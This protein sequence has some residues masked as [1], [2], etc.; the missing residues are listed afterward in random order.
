VVVSGGLVLGAGYVLAGLVGTSFVGLLIT[1]GVVAGAGIG[2]AYVVPIAVGVRWFPDMKGLITGLAVAGFGF[3][4]LIWVKLAG[5]WGHLIETAGVSN[6]FMIYGVVF[7]LVVLAGSLVMKLP[8]EGWLPAGYVPPAAGAGDGAPLE[9]G[10]AAMLRTPQFHLLW[11]MFVFGA[12]AGLQVIGTIKLFGIDALEASGLDAATASAT[13]GTAMA[14]FYSLSNGFGRIAWGAISDRIG[15]KPALVIMMTLQGVVMLAFYRMGGS[16][17]LLYLGAALIGFNFG[18]N[19][20]LFPAATADYF[21]SRFLGANYGWVFS[22]Y[23]L[24]GIFGPMLGGIVRDQT[25]NFLFA[26]VPAG[27]ACLLAA[28]LGVLLTPPLTPAD[29]VKSRRPVSAMQPQ[30][31]MVD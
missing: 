16:P 1:I 13:A 9:L 31:A 28:L 30:S 14:V 29:R 27:I 5:S 2:L 11:V 17:A 23:G 4:A 7:A 21:G 3:G 12:M 8:P 10:P 6:V 19:F 25:G 18:G 20:A 26:F 22:A 15:R 24:G